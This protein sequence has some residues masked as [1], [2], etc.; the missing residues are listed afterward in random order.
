M[1]VTLTDFRD[2]ARSVMD[3]GTKRPFWLLEDRALL[4][5]KPTA[6]AAPSLRS[7]LCTSLDDADLCT[8]SIGIVPLVINKMRAKKNLVENSCKFNLQF[9]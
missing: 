5:W 2:L 4:I 6:K 8:S 9:I 1:H 7:P 3:T